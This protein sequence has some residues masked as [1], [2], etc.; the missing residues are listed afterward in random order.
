[1][2]DSLKLS[3]ISW[4]ITIVVIAGN[5]II[6]R[7]EVPVI[8]S[9]SWGIIILILLIIGVT[10]GIKGMKGGKRDNIKSAV[11]QGC[12]GTVL[13]SIMLLFFILGVIV[14]IIMRA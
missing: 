3:R 13:N 12:I 5:A 8:V 11:I 2:D 9:F 10:V 4:I 14:P 7:L 6:G 1:M